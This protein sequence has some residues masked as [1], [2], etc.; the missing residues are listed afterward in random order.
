MPPASVINAVCDELCNHIGYAF[1]NIGI[2]VNYTRQA[3]VVILSY[4]RWALPG[5]STQRPRKP[6]SRNAMNRRSP[7][8][9]VDTS[10]VVGVAPEVWTTIC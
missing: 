5:S 3:A 10:I 1:A 7:L 2:T 4:K 8:R 9:S 6:C